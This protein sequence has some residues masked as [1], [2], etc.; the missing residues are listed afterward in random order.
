M[1]TAARPLRVRLRIDD[2]AQTRETTRVASSPRGATPLETSSE[3]LEED[4][5]VVCAVGARC[6]RVSAR[7]NAARE[8]W[9]ARDWIERSVD[10]REI[11]NC[12]LVGDGRSWTVEVAPE[13]SET[14]ASCANDVAERARAFAASGFVRP[15]AV[16]ETDLGF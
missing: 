12:A 15:D 7:V 1:A 16:E 5:L 3:T 2:D 9:D 8:D 14:T 6:V 10:M 4:E 11:I 13:R